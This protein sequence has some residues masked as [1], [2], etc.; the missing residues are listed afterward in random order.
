MTIIR[1]SWEKLNKPNNV[2]VEDQIDP[3]KK[4]DIILEPFE[5]G[6]GHTLC[7]TLRRVMLSYVSGF[8]VTSI[9]IDDVLHEYA[10]IEGVKE[11]VVDIIMNIKSLIISKQDPAACV[12]K[13][14]ANKEG[15]VLASEIETPA[16]VEILNKDLV[17][18][19]L[20]KGASIN[21]QM[22][23]EFGSGYVAAGSKSKQ[24]LPVGTILIDTIFSPIK[25]FNYKVED[26][27][28]GDV[29]N[30]DKV[31]ISV[32][33]D[34]T[35][36]PADAIG[37]ASKIIQDQME[38]FINFEVEPLPKSDSESEGE[39]EF[40]KNLIKSIEELELSVRSYNCLKNEKIIYVGDLVSKSESDMLKTSN[41]GRKSLNELKDNLKEM[42]LNFGMKLDNWPPANLEELSKQKSKEF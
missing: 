7:N 29:I 12:L 19:N 5:K 26:S 32:E 35:I 34:G 42:G 41:F 23:V 40:N 37:V 4:A 16:G 30:Y 36:Q 20:N 24:D 27:R 31:T 18:C 25:K 6:F 22:N 39:E 38:I 17:I 2:V 8:A 3:N 14:S 21:M 28:I 13:L 33:T 9:K 1:D 10:S 11:D 15:A